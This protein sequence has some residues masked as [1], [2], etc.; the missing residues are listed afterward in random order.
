VLKEGLLEGEE[1]SAAA[2]LLYQSQVQQRRR[3]KL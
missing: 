3:R 2:D 1:I